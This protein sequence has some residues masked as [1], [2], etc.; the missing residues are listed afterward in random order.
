MSSPF[1]FPDYR[2]VYNFA[3]KYRSQ[4]GK[5]ALRVWLHRRQIRAF[6]AFANSNP[7]YRALFAKRPQDAYPLLHAFIDKRFGA[8]ERLAAMQYDI[9]A[10]CRLFPADTL[11]KLDTPDT[12]VT[13]ALLSDGLSIVLNRNG[14]CSDEGLWAVTLTDGTGSRLYNATFALLPAGLAAASVQGPSGGEAKDTVRRLTKQLHGLRPQQLMA[15][16]IQYLAAALGLDALGIAHDCQVKLRWKLKKRVKMNYDQYWQESAAVLGGD[17]Y[18]HLPAAPP[19]KDLA[20]IESK[21]RSMYRKRYQ[22]FDDLEAAVNT[23]FRRPE[24]PAAA[25]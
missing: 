11:A 16:V 10:A 17:G 6:E 22:M 24:H 15:A 5:F 18:W 12:P 23:H 9:A 21:K 20:E 4:H 2:A 7:A 13:L 1:V 25:V 3:P 19:R 8:R 14:I